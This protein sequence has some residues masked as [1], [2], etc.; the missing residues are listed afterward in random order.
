M[1]WPPPG[2]PSAQW[3]MFK[4]PPHSPQLSAIH[5]STTDS[6]LRLEFTILKTTAAAL[7]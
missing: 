4:P 7:L 6:V 1:A 3:T 5:T 2:M